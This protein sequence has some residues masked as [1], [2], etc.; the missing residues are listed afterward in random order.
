MKLVFMGTPDF[1]VPTLEQLID[2]GHRVAAVST[3]PPQPAGRGLDLRRSAVH[4][5]AE[6]QG[7]EVHTPS[8]LKAEAEWRALAALG[9]DLIVVVAYGLVL[10]PPALEA[11]RLGAYNLHASL[12]PRWRG[13]APGARALTARGAG[14]GRAGARVRAGGC[15]ATRG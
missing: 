12:L 9:A 7:L 2:D 4:E 15:T 8:S 1:A 10:P 5:A 14:A 6:R 13:A 11:A 3:Q